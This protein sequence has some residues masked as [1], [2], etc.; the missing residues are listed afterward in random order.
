VSESSV[1]VYAL[2]EAPIVVPRRCR[3]MIQIVPVGGLFAALEH[4]VEKPQLSEP[5]LRRQHDIV[6]SLHQVSDAILPVRFGAL[7]DMDELTEVI[8]LRRRS[9]AKALERVRGREQMSIR[10]F[11]TAVGARR[12]PTRFPSSGADYLRDR[13]ASARPVLSA[14][15][16]RIIEAVTS[17]ATARSI[18]AGRGDVQ[19]TIHHLIHRGDAERYRRLVNLRA[20]SSRPAARLTVSGPW[21]PFAFAPDI[22]AA[23]PERLLETSQR[24]LQ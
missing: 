4:R 24:E 21:P 17:L 22:W 13:A 6:V 12:R 20:A 18:D 23:N 5:A 19:V 1:Y 9:L 7:V 15:A 2:L 3:P 14:S 16:R 10:I 11:G 8:R